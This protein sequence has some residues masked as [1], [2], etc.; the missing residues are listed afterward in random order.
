MFL[1]KLSFLCWAEILNSY[2]QAWW[3]YGYLWWNV[4]ETCHRFYFIFHIQG[5]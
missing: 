4:K 3:N 1:E 2:L 5:T